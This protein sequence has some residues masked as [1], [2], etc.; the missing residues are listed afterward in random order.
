MCVASGPVQ[1][2][3]QRL[4]VFVCLFNY[5]MSNFTLKP[6]KCLP[7]S[8]APAKQDVERALSYPIIT[9]T[10][11]PMWASLCHCSAHWGSAVLCNV[12][13]LLPAACRWL[14]WLRPRWRA[15]Q[16]KVQTLPFTGCTQ[17]F[18]RGHQRCYQ[19]S[20]F[21]QG[22]EGGLCT[23]VLCLSHC[24]NRVLW[25]ESPARHQ[26]TSFLSNLCH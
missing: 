10:C 5:W 19:L 13:Q 16:C 21:P 17:H 3:C 22:R 11:Q 8:W 24:S 23:P 1:P 14:S 6:L 15:V 2:A 25:K 26:E 12:L 9:T 18:W 7:T 20:K 4:V